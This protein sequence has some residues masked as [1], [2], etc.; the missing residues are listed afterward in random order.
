MRKLEPLFA[1]RDEAIRNIPGFWRIVLSQ[2]DEFADYIRASDFKYVDA[3]KSVVVKW[4]DPR[5]YEVEIQF[6]CIE[7]ELKEQTV[8]KK[9]I[10]RGEKLT[11]EPVA[12]DFTGRQRKDTKSFLDWFSWTGNSDSKEFPNGAQLAA[13]LSEDIYPYC[14]KYYSEAQRDVADEESSASEGELL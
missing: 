12:L 14:A 4:K 10:S 3:I 5:D 8:T 2:H 9:F 13:L 6:N 1:K 7:N 11:S